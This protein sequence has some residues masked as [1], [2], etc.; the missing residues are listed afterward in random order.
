[1]K[2]P[3]TT[4][5]IV[6]PAFN[7]GPTI[8]RILDKIKEVTLIHEIQKEIIIVNDF[9]TDNT[10]D[11]LQKYMA[12]HADENIKYFAHMKKQLKSI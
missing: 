4:L 8:H 3:F 10:F 9:S 12:S 11:E 7:E 5:S 2:T 1:M 6:I